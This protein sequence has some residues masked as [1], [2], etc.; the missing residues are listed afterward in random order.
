MA[1]K[2]MTGL[3]AGPAEERHAADEGA[4]ADTAALPQKENIAVQSNADAEPI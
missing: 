1:A 2:G 4:A 3:P